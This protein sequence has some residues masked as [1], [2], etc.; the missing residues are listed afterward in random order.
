M[1][2]KR[3]KQIGNTVLTDIEKTE[4]T[5][6]TSESKEAVVDKVEDI[7]HHTNAK[8]GILYLIIQPKNCSDICK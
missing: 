5:E 4:L 1:Q 6:E 7:C 2:R 3:K 8:T